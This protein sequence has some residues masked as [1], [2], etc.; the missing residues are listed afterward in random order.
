MSVDCKVVEKPNPQKRDEV[1]FY[2]Q[3]IR[4]GTITRAKLE[5]GIIRET[6]LSKADVRG[7]VTVLSDLFGD[8]LTEGYNISLD[9]LGTFSLR[10]Q[11]EG[12][13]NEEEASVRNIKK[14]SVGFRPAVALRDK[15][16]KT[17]FV[18]K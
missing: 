10:V 2:V 9:E 3:P 15:V 12:S 16:S 8:Y 1:K 14:L 7:V 6:S 17:K 4:K 11:S 5:E 18:K 13:E